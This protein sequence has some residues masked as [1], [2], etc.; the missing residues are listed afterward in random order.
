MLGK[1]H[2]TTGIAS[3]LMITQPNTVPEVIGTMLGGAIGGWIV[4]IDIKDREIDREKV[5][6][7]IIDAL[8]I[9]AFIIADYLIGNGM[10][11]YVQDNWGVK[12]WGAL[13]AI[14][15]L[16]LI[17]FNTRHR[18]FTHSLIGMVLFGI[19][20]WLFC[21]PITIS[22]LIGY[23]SHLILDLF[24]KKG[25]QLFFP[26]KWK[27]CLK[28]CHA[29]K[30]AN[31]IIFWIALALDVIVGAMLFSNSLMMSGGVS[32]FVCRIKDVK[33]LG[34]NKLQIYLIFINIL[35]FLVF[36]RS[37]KLA[38]REEL[39]EKDKKL[40]IQLDFE[41]WLMDILVFLGGGVGMFLSLVI[42]LQYPS[43]Y[44]ANWWSI[45]YTSIMFWG[46]LYC[47]IC[48]PFGLVIKDI[49]WFTTKHIP[50]L[51]YILGIN[52]I[53]A[54]LFYTFRKRRFGEYHIAHTLLFMMGALGGTIGAIPVVI[55]THRE[56]T[57]SYVSFGF[58]VMLISQIVFA[59]YMMM[60]GIF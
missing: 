30:R 36:M 1:T 26:L 54:L 37:A 55:S 5:Y 32:E 19:S 51:V 48:N 40:Q 59:M 27:F 23:M 13:M 22:F 4:D 28:I 58:F 11:K 33:I 38:Y 45:C 34:L 24:N 18:T 57:Y 25:L 53:S 10:C 7:C 6:N 56:G 42:H 12:V 50:L 35:T 43:A 21:E 31:R 16:M 44:N 8:F 47:Y 60:V 52:S 15:I 3:A 49:V 39:A 2:I 41:T 29:D 14:A 9:G 20:T 46:T 17:G